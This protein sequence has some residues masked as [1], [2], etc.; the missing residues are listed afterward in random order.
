MGQPVR[1]PRFPLLTV[2]SCVSSCPCCPT[3]A[4]SFGGSLERPPGRP[5]GPQPP[6]GTSWCTSRRSPWSPPRTHMPVTSCK[7]ELACL[8]VSR[9]ASQQ[10]APHVTARL[11]LPLSF[12]ASAML[13]VPLTQQLTLGASAVWCCRFWRQVPGHLRC[14]ESNCLGLVWGIG[15][16]GTAWVYS[17][18]YGQQ[19]APGKRAP[20]A[21]DL[22]DSHVLSP[23]KSA[24]LVCF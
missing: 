6:R 18:R 19:P 21:V 17:G 14:V 23:L 5:C 11:V 15:W 16:D 22:F 12:C 10:S 8:V 20:A 4:A 7:Y 24:S 9:L 3:L 2:L 1:S 13:S